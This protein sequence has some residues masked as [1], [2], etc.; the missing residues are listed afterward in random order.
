MS[1]LHEVGDI[2]VNEDLVFLDK[3]WRFQRIG[4]FVIGLILLLAALGAFGRG[5]LSDDQI[6]DPNTLHADYHRI[7]RHG[8][9]TDL[10]LRVGPSTSQDSTVRL[11]IST[12]YLKDFEV[13]DIKP[14]P[15]ASGTA[16]GV[17]FYEFERS[18]PASSVAIIMTLK[19]QGFW[20]QNATLG[21]PGSTPLKFNQFVLP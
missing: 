21:L 11:L 13:V 16:D 12:E 18:D 20:S 1:E 17:F 6:G 14:E 10:T 7:L 9:D 3:E 2:Q 19:P 15:S 4:W 5:L 8:A